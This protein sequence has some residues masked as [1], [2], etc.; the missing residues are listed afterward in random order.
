MFI[1]H[2]ACLLFGHCPNYIYLAVSNLHTVRCVTEQADREFNLRPARIIAHYTDEG[3][4]TSY[5]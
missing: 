2:A 5:G 1:L 4:V 3:K